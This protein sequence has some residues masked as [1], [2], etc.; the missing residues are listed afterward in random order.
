[1]RAKQTAD[2]IAEK[3][4]KPIEQSDL[5][6]EWNQGAHRLGKNA[7]DQALWE[8]SKALVETFKESNH[9]SADEENFE[10]LNRRAGDAIA[11]LLERPEENIAVVSHGWFSPVL[12]GKAIIGDD[13]TGR[14]CEHFIKTLRMKNTGLT[15]LVYDT[16]RWWG[17]WNLLTWNDHAHLG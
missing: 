17:G 8:Q 3:I 6:V 11:Y 12:V 1:M 16:E 2:I 13:F 4:G 5:F 7:N 15:V 14:D 9:R 10:D